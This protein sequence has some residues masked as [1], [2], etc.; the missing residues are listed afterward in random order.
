MDD[1]TAKNRIESLFYEVLEN[2]LPSS[3]GEIVKSSS[4]PY[5]WWTEFPECNSFLIL[6]QKGEPNPHP[7]SE[8]VWEHPKDVTNGEYYLLLEFDPDTIEDAVTI[9]ML[10]AIK[11]LRVY[12]RFAEDLIPCTP[13]E[14]I[15]VMNPRKMP[16]P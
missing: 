9:S 5:A 6:L 16:L 10:E 15:E 14:A 1:T 12:V 3:L 13:A 8:Y 4:P 7:V 11:D 2:Y